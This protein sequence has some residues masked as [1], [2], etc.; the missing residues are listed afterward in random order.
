MFIN[1]YIV[2]QNFKDELKKWYVLV[3]NFVITFIVLS[4]N[5][6]RISNEI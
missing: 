2:L 3:K 5:V 6:T 4:N 1:Q